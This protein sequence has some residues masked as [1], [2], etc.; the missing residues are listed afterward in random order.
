MLAES[1][2]VLAAPPGHQGEESPGRE[3]D[4][5]SS[6]VVGS[7]ALDD[8]K[9]SPCGPGLAADGRD[10]IDQWQELRDIV[11]IGARK[12]YGQ[13]SPFRINKDMVF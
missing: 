13:R 3:L 10:R 2:A 9:L 4:A 6:G 12:C 7:I 11:A 1:A 8:R 5:V